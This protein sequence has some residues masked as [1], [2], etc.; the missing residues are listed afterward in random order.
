MR[1]HCLRPLICPIC[2][3][4]LQGYGKTW[5]CLAGHSFDVAREG[6]VNLLLSRKKLAATVGDTA[7]M[8]QARRRFLASG[9]YDGLCAAVNQVAAEC[10]TGVS[11]SPTAVLDAGCGEGYYI[12]QVRRFLEDDV[13]MTV[14]T[15]GTDVAKAAIKLAAKQYPGAQF[16]VADTNRFIPCAD[17]S[18]HLL[19]NMFAPRHPAE[20]V[21]VLAPGGYLLV[22]IPGAEHL[23]QL[24]A[25][26]NLLDME[27]EKR[28]RVMAQFT[29]YLALH[30]ERPLTF[31]LTLTNQQLNDLVQMMPSARHLTPAQQQALQS[32]PAFT[33][34]AQFHLLLFRKP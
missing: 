32:A 8:L 24:R 10:L 33:T 28:A 25:Q 14:C 1:D 34:F 30:A 5:R 18:I 3:T 23:A 21:R 31:P 6:Y 11:G 29:P 26:F 12:N 19:F 7:V 16:L 13:G 17:Q 2:R 22:V 15:F 27:A 20:F 9:A 4:S